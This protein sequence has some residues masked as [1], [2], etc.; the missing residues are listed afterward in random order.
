MAPAVFDTQMY[1]RRL[2][3]TRMCAQYGFLAYAA[4]RTVNVSQEINVWL[5]VLFKWFP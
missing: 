1:R 3:E 5:I 2:Q 4:S